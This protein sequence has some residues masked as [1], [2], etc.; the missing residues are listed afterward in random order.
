MRRPRL[1]FVAAPPR[2]QVNVQ[3][4]LA[5]M[6]AKSTADVA[7]ATA[8]A[9]ARREADV[10]KVGAFWIARVATLQAEMKELARGN[11]A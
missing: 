4:V 10:Q 11:S 5:F 8:A 7:A 9:Q 3:K 1:N 2:L 6:L